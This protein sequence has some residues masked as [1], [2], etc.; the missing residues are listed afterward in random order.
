MKL[1]KLSLAGAIVAIAFLSSCSKGT[2]GATGATGPAGPDSVLHSSW[3]NFDLVGALDL[4]GDS[5]YTQTVADA[6]ITQSILDSGVVDVY[7]EFLDPTGAEF[8]EPASGYVETQIYLG[9]I[10]VNSYPLDE[11][12]LGTE[13]NGSAAFRY[14][15]I[16]GTI[17]TGNSF[18][19]LSKAQIQTLSY[20]KL[21]ALLTASG[22]KPLSNATN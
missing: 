4:Y 10:V 20:E 5:V 13:L 11:G 9:S 2:N 17:L 14:V 7:V 21:S 19:G 12:G 16:P 22:V 15:I 18:K 8:I 3:T 6:N 1:L